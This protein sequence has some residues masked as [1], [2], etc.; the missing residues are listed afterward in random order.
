MRREEE[1]MVRQGILKVKR[2]RQ[3]LKR[4]I[5]PPIQH[6]SASL[7]ERQGWREG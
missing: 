5:N 1:E 3:D 6:S 2:E 4:K 7:W